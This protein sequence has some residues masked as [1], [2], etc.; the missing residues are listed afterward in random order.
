MWTSDEDFRAVE[1]IRAARER[2]PL[3][4]AAISWLV[5][6]YLEGAVPDYQMSAWLMAVALNGLDEDATLWLTLAM[7][8]S[9]ACL[10]WD[11]LPAPAVDKHSTGGV[12]DKV[13][14]IVVPIVAAAG[15]IVPKLSGRG[16]GFTGGTLDKLESIPGLRTALSLSE[17]RAQ[18]SRVGCAIAAATQELVPADRRLYALRDATA[19]V[20]SMPLV[21]SSIMSKKL[22][23][24]AWSLVLD[25]KTGGGAIMQAEADARALAQRMVAIGQGAGRQV[26]AVL[27]RMDQPL[28]ATVGNALE[29]GEAIE[30]LRGGGP[31]D[32]RELALTLAG[33]MIAL[34]VAS[35]DA[36][37]GREKAAAR[38]ADGS[39]LERFRMMVEAQGGDARCVDGR[40]LPRAPAR[41]ELRAAE[42]GWVSA[43]DA[44][45]V[46]FTAVGLGAGRDRPG[47]EVDPSVGI[48]LMR[49]VGD[50]VA[51]GDL[52]AE[53]HA[54][55]PAEAARALERLRAAYRIAPAA[56][57]VPD[58]LIEVIGGADV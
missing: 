4:Q 33:W 21:A 40:R 17:L 37:A 9:G 1:I 55:S 8:D 42:D 16:L 3:P 11:D 51:P 15:L 54:R 44:R 32:L 5:R 28:G 41:Q 13:S 24:G 35:P 14:L 18:V 31:A 45:E 6:A 53:V 29:V 49:R 46:G 20:E 39:A 30:V 34:G 27:S 23:G 57:A 36:G 7:R 2:R 43:I 50:P 10:D 19:T 58:T 47:A 22:A 38:L 25:V 12:G 48:V 26:V 52:L 56:P